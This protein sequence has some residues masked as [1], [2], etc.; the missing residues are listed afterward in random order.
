VALPCGFLTVP[1]LVFTTGN[2]PKTFMNSPCANVLLQIGQAWLPGFPPDGSSTW[3]PYMM[4]Q[5]SVCVQNAQRQAVEVGIE[6]NN[7]RSIG[8]LRG[9]A[10]LAFVSCF[11]E[12]REHGTDSFVIRRDGA[13]CQTCDATAPR[14]CFFWL[15]PVNYPVFFA[16]EPVNYDVS[17]LL[18]S[19]G[20]WQPVFSGMQFN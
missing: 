19:L 17:L 20:S 8:T 16:A 6:T 11:T 2:S 10:M 4:K 15:S 12:L 18:I 3:P 5:Y 1:L 13:A 7:E 9:A 14:P